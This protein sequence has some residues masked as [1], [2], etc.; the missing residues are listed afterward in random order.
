MSHPVALTR[1][2][3]NAIIPADA[4]PDLYIN[5]PAEP[6][7]DCATDTHS[8]ALSGSDER[9]LVFHIVALVDSLRVTDIRTSYDD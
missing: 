7:T 6:R 2:V 1:A 5:R 4:V 9:G 8:C 3:H